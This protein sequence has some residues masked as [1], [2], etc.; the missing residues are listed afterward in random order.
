[1]AQVQRV[2]P[3]RTPLAKMMSLSAVTMLKT[4]IG[5]EMSAKQKLFSQNASLPRA[6]LLI[7]LSVHAPESPEKQDAVASMASPKAA[8][9]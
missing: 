4:P 9:E 1:M 3:P 7:S 5:I 8:C 2:K 6:L